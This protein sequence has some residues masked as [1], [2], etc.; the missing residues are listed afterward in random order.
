MQYALQ[1][2]LRT[3]A[4]PK[5][6]A[7]C[8]ICRTI[9]IAKCGTQR[10]SHWAHQGLK[11]CDSWKENETQW[12]REWKKKFP[13][14]WREYIQHDESGEKHI[15]D[16]RTVHGLVI[17]FQHSHLDPEER[18][19]REHFHKNMVWVVDGTRLKKDYPRFQKGINDLLTK[20]KEGYFLLPNPEICFLAD[21]LNSSVHVFF[22]FLGV[23]AT[24]SPDALRQPLWCLRPSRMDGNAVITQISRER[25]VE[26]ATNGPQTSQT[27]TNQP[28]SNMRVPV[29]R[30]MVDLRFLK[31][32]DPRL[33]RE[34]MRPPQRRSFRRL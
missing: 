13:P 31:Q 30:V 8:P 33:Y 7:V 20:K 15:A 12:H 16:V 34:I 6:R 2:D 5:G 24:D 25:F 11:N 3:E 10:I 18:K 14:D 26:L 21:W 9:V 28:T 29:Q 27:P 1:D 23:M 32:I 19:A 4:S 17:E 22:D